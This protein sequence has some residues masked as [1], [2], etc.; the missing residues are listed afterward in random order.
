MK[1]LIVILMIVSLLL[2][3]CK[4]EVNKTQEQPV[5]EQPAVEQSQTE[6]PTDV[7]PETNEE[8]TVSDEETE[9]QQPSET[10]LRKGAIIPLYQ[11]IEGSV[12]IIDDKGKMM[13]VLSDDFLIGTGDNINVYLI[14]SP[15]ALEASEVYKADKV[16]LGKILSHEGRQMFEIPSN[17]DLSKYKAVT[18]LDINSDVV[19]GN[20]R[21]S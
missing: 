5:I 6:Q 1:R 14:S 15:R 19:Y 8:E 3:A 11:K 21:L 4:T 20:A 2:T 13:L 16:V 12:K 9:V 17:T 10:I 7:I 18:F